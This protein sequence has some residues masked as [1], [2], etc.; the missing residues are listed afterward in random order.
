MASERLQRQIERT[1]DEAEEAISRFD[2]DALLQCANAVL[3]M[4]PGNTDALAF[5]ATAERALATPPSDESSSVPQG[6]APTAQPAPLASAPEA[7]RRQLT[8]MFCDLQGSTALS[9]QLDP[10]VLRDV[11]RGYQE[12]CAGAV[13]RFEGHIAKYLGDGCRRGDRSAS[14]KHYESLIPGRGTVTPV[15]SLVVDRVLGLLAQTFDDP[16]LDLLPLR[17]RADRARYRKRP[18]QSHGPSRRIP[19]HLYRPGNAAADGAADPLEQP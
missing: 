12:V 17:R 10:E 1:L 13:G 14:T 3:A 6:A 2:W 11:I 19:S 7:E 9:Q 4:D 15:M 18:C 16:S 5:Q 8:V